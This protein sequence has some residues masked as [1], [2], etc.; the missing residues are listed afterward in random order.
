MDMQASSSPMVAIPDPIQQAVNR[1]HGEL[2][3]LFQVVST[4]TNKNGQVITFQ[5][6]LLV[7]PESG[8]HE[9]ERRLERYGYT[10]L[11]RHERGRDILVAVQGLGGK[12][13]TGN[14]WV[15]LLL[16]LV[17]IL[18]TLSAGAGMEGYDVIAALRSGSM[19][20][21]YVVLRAGAPFSVSLLSILGVHEL[22]H[23]VASRLHGVAASLPYFI[24]MP[25]GDLGTLGAF[26]ALRSPLRNRKVLFDVGLSGPIAGLFVALPLLLIGIW[27]S[28]PV[29]EFQV[30]YTLRAAGSSL[31]VQAM[32]DLLHPL[33]EGYTLLMHPV[34]FA[35][36]IGL[37]VT[38]INLLPAG[39]L[40]G[41]HVAYALLGRRA[42]LVAMLVF[43]LLIIA[44]VILSDNWLVIGF[45]VLVIGLSHPP[46]LNDL[47]KLDPV[48][49]LLGWGTLVLFILT[50]V[51]A[52]F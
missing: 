29:P 35:A 13:K 7:E 1:L 9:L 2:F 24:P 42:N 51:P 38:S 33:P 25:F 52:P 20:N 4:K 44:G 36:W 27:L 30:G 31:L 19:E 16:L 34:F 22:G 26:I 45:F 47:T 41:G 15:N 10:P 43:F 23:Y 40:D 6:K 50:V 37:F 32:I 17:T 49:R 5:G 28:T 14:P 39:Q 11:L 46:P 3:G 21:L 18:T 48:R 8:Y 12:E